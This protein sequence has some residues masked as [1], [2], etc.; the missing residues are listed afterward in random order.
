MVVLD[1]D[2]K[3]NI[4]S[5]LCNSNIDEFIIQS[6]KSDNDGIKI[7]LYSNKNINLSK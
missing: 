3:I 6:A 1:D 7:D 2:E 4:F 5:P